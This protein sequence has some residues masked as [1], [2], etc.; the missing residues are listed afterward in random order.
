VH[1][2]DK[3]KDGKFIRLEIIVTRNHPVH[4]TLSTYTTA[5]VNIIAGDYAYSLF[6]HATFV[7]RKTFPTRIPDYFNGVVLAKKYQDRGWTFVQ[8][9]PQGKKDRVTGELALGRRRI[10]DRYT[11]KMRLSP[12]MDDGVGDGA[13]GVEG[14]EFEIARC[15]DVGF[16]LEWLSV[17]AVAQEK[18]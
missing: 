3:E 5:L 8:K 17:A 4:S 1:Q 7:S 16:G 18:E 15:E 12:E 9:V 14:V 13:E 2:Y 11:W 6:P 10:G